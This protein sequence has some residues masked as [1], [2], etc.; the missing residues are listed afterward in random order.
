MEAG[1]RR[2][3]QVSHLPGA[4]HPTGP[5]TA[6][7]YPP[8]SCCLLPRPLPGPGISA[9][10]PTSPA[11][12]AGKGCG[13][14]PGRRESARSPRDPSPELGVG[15][16]PQ[17]RDGPAGGE[18]RS[19]DHF[20]CSGPLLPPSPPPRSA[21]ATPRHVPA[22]APPAPARSAA[23]HHAGGRGSRDR[24]G[25]CELCA[26]DGRGQGPG[27]RSP[28]P[29]RPPP[30]EKFAARKGARGGEGGEGRGGRDAGS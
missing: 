29:P 28:L 20:P 13:P 12:K 2:T 15:S 22:D 19:A 23:T 8:I 25:A 16:P 9:G 30:P 24:R 26:G 6:Q 17:A 27:R 21:A 11:V 7:M 1:L 5:P 14:T 18:G 4:S 3:Q 10:C